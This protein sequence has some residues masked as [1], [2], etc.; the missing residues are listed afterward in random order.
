VDC[1]EGLRGWIGG[2]RRIDLASCICLAGVEFCIIGSWDNC[3]SA[4][5]GLGLEDGLYEGLM[6]NKL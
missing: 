6:G 5:F 4:L 2:R 1:V 3:I